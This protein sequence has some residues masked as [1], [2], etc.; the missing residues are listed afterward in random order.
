MLFMNGPFLI[1]VKI[2]FMNGPFLISVKMLF[3]NGP[4]L[5][6]EKILFMNHLLP[7]PEFSS[8]RQFQRGKL[9]GPLVNL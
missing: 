4:F 9:F 2:L 8:A 6:S 7:I 5:I 3:M 1:S